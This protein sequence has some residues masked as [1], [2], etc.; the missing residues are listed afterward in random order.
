MKKPEATQEMGF[1]V[2]TLEYPRCP[3]C[4]ATRRHFRHQGRRGSVIHYKCKACLVHFKV[5]VRGDG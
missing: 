3:A 2:Q 5:L 1:P 4:G